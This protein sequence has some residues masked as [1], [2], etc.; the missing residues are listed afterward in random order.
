MTLLTAELGLFSCDSQQKEAIQSQHP[1]IVLIVS[2][3][4]GWKDLGCYGNPVHETPNIDKLA[5]EG[6]RFT[7]AYAAAPVSTPTRAPSKQGNTRHGYTLPYGVNMRGDSMAY[8][9]V[10]N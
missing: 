5:E 10:R 6:V 8:E 4:M 3:D 2:D 9:K 7:N 1:N